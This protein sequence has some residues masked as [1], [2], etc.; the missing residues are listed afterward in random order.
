MWYNL[1]DEYQ[2]AKDIEN[3]KMNSFIKIAVLGFIASAFFGCSHAPKDTPHYTISKVLK[4]DT[5]TTIDV[6]IARRMSPAE[7]LLIA[8]KVKADSV[9]FQNL[10]VHYL[11]PATPT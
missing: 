6:H 11:L 5:L 4:T 7:L 8:G 9:K 3:K 2:E 10:A 1:G